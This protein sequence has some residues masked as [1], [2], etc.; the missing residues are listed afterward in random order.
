VTAIAATTAIERAT[1]PKEP[2]PGLRPFE[3]HER[4]IFFGREEMIDTVI[5]GLAR[6]NLVVIHGASGSGK[7]SLVR[8]G[9]L[10]WLEIQ[11]GRRRGWLTAI[12]RPAGSPLRNL[13]SALAE[14]LGFPR[15]ASEENDAIAS[16]YTRLALGQSVLSD[17][18]AVLKEKAAS[19]RLLIDQFEELFRYTRENSRE[20]AALVTSLLCALAGERNPAPHLFVILTMRS[21]YLGECAHFD[22]FA[23]TVNTCQYLLPR[24]NDFGILRAIHEPATLYGG[25]VD[26]A[27]GDHLLFAARRE[28]DVLPVLQHTL[29]RA[30]FWARKRHR[31][32]RGWTVTLDDLQVVEGSD[33][34]LSKHADEVLA[35]LE[36]RDAR[37][38]KTAEWT[39]RSLAEL[40]S[41]GRAIRHPCSFK[42]LVDIADGDR[43]GVT[44]VIEAFRGAGCNFLT[45]DPPGTLTDDS[46][47]DISHQA[48]IRHWQRLCNPARDPATK[49]PVGWMWRE[50]KDGQRW[51]ALAVQ[52]RLFR[53]DASESATLSPNTVHLTI[54]KP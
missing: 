34:A 52:A 16:W 12:R 3:P 45:T 14:C 35:E 6:K 31:E 46:K 48:L 50:F 2:Y 17:V 11:Q 24:L 29:M 40:D 53:D 20:E 41:E 37:L 49:E 33:G 22:G 10:P 27:V 18:E 32:D 44:A 8:A 1:L 26:A 4:R 38:L 23:E 13:A 28:E 42:A 36:V 19:L 43:A 39:F 5:D 21:D 9:V 25:E 51:R 30:C 15:N 47:I 54:Y 7:S